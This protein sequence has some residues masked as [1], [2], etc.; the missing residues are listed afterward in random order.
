M[1]FVKIHQ[2][3]AVQNPPKTTSP[4]AS[5]STNTT[6]TT[7]NTSTNI[8]PTDISPIAK[9]E[10]ELIEKTNDIAIFELKFLNAQGASVDSSL[11]KDGISLSVN[12]LDIAELRENQLFS[13][14]IIDGKARIHANLKS[15]GSLMIYALITGKNYKSPVFNLDS[16]VESL[17]ETDTEVSTAEEAA[18]LQVEFKGNFVPNMPLELTVK[19]LGEDMALVSN[20]TPEEAVTFVLSSGGGNFV[21]SQLSTG[22][23]KSGVAALEFIPDSNS[24][25]RFYATDGKIKSEEITLQAGV[26]KDVSSSHPNY[27]AIRY[28]RDQGVIGGY[29]DGTFK[30]EKAISRVEVLKIILGALNY[31]KRDDSI[32]NFTDTARGTWYSPFLA[33]AV[34]S[35]IVN[36]YPDRSFRPANNVNTAEFFKMLTLSTGEEL[37]EEISEKPFRDVEPSDWFA[38]YAAYANK[39]RVLSSEKLYFDAGRNITRGEVADAIYRVLMIQKHGVK[40]YRD[41]LL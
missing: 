35:G 33:T 9:I 3:G 19:A 17:T 12:S 32:V 25:V 8:N 2:S 1:E 31:E 15:K 13:G 16:T 5:T 27:K 18:S 39:K 41:G 40:F 26:F 11:I 28:L 22:A 23:F 14:D 29:D 24:T 38:P 7:T 36:G 34:G 37:E 30:P 21:P 4:V 10:F 6:N 20:Y